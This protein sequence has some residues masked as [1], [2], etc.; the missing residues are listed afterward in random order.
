MVAQVVP[1]TQ[2][3]F[4][5]SLREIELVD[6]H[7]K[8]FEALKAVRMLHEKD[9]QEVTWFVAPTGGN[10]LFHGQS[11]RQF[12]TP[13]V[14]DTT[15]RQSNQILIANVVNA[16]TN[17]NSRWFEFTAEEEQ[18]PSFVGS[19]GVL[20]FEPLSTH[21]EANEWL[22]VAT[23]TAYKV[24]QSTDTRFEVAN[25]EALSTIITYGTGGM[26]VT[27][28]PVTH[29]VMRFKPVHLSELFIDEDQHGI[30]DTV[31]NRFW[32]TAREAV[33]EWGDKCGKQILEAYQNQ[34]ERHFEFMHVV[35][36]AVKND[37]FGQT[38]NP[39]R[40]PFFSCYINVAEKRIMSTGPFK[41]NP[42]L[43]GRMMRIPG[44]KYGISPAIQGL[45]DTKMVNKMQL[46]M[47]LAQE[48]GNTPP[49]LT[50][51]DGIVSRQKI[52][53]NGLI[54]GGL[55]P[56]GKPQMVPLQSGAR[57]DWSVAGIQE[58]Q[59]RIRANFYIDLLTLPDNNNMTATEIR[60]RNQ[61]R[62]RLLGPAAGRLE[63]EY[64]G[65]LV[66]RVFE[67]LEEHNC[68]P[69]RPEVLQGRKIKI[70]YQGPLTRAQKSQD[71][72]ALIQFLETVAPL[73][74]LNPQVLDNL[75]MDA[76]FRANA[77]LFGLP[78]DVMRHMS[79]VNELR[80]NAQAQQNEQLEAQQRDLTID[81]VAK[82]AKAGI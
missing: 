18:V 17:P 67:L 51:D 20:H 41:S 44:S 63:S 48:L 61:E 45:P 30:I 1:I 29:E 73:V 58:V 75:D 64:V 72:Y 50:T 82:L 19:D 47:I 68:L 38:R 78:P 66:E 26:M 10:F 16:L 60:S 5:A 52:K 25:H 4:S 24:F 59:T 74:E 76:Q 2:G 3:E 11:S 15:A 80:E 54:L 43:I 9:W 57:M 81:Q 37:H 32:W 39:K 40:F 23:D 12:Q 34:P 36:K 71:A 77:A 49:W 55:S 21:T 65:P 56:D 42:Y 13:Y 31:Y 70:V 62:L 7:L 53:P 22:K 46:N 35:V 8:R 33:L 14:L 69:P 79:Q 28:H 27:Y 6:R